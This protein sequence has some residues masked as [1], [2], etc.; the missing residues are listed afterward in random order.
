[1]SAE[2]P[3]KSRQRRGQETYIIVTGDMASGFEFYSK[4]DDQQL[5]KVEGTPWE[6][7]AAAMDYAEENLCEPWSIVPL[8]PLILK[9]EGEKSEV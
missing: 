5:G 8:K 7:M 2:L 1:M 3:T 6:S 9:Q 4:P